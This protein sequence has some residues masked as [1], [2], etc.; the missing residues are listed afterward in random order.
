MRRILVEIQCSTGAYAGAKSVIRILLKIKQLIADIS[1][2]YSDAPTNIMMDASDTA[3]G[4]VLQPINN[5]W[6]SIAFLSKN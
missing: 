2:S 3:V 6:K 4:A 1:L 5:G